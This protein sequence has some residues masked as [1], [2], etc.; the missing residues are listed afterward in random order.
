MKVSR[1]PLPHRPHILR[2]TLY[3]VASIL[4]PPYNWTMSLILIRLR[5]LREHVGLTQEELAVKVGVRQGT[6]SAQETGESQGISYEL[7]EALAVAL[8]VEPGA[9]FERVP[10]RRKR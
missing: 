10:K 9:L 8:G 6:I 1:P 2:Y 7:L 4:G 3:R 5:E